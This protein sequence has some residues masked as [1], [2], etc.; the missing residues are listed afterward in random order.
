MQHLCELKTDEAVLQRI[1]RLPPKLEDLY[2]E[3]HEKLTKYPAE[4]DRRI[5]RNTLSWLLCAQ[6]PLNSAEFL[7]AVSTSPRGF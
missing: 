7:A 4:A 2:N 5:A 3:L 6:R 1:G